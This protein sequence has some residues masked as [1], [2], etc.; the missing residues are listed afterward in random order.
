[1][2]KSSVIIYLFF[3][4]FL[5]FVVL[6][7][8]LA[9]NSNQQGHHQG[10]RIKNVD[11]YSKL[12][13]DQY[14]QRWREGL[15]YDPGHD[16]VEADPVDYIIV[17][18][19]SAGS[20]LANR[21]SAEENKFSVLVI[22]A[23]PPDATLN[24]AIEDPFEM[25][26]L[27]HT[28]VDWGYWT[29]NQ[30][31][32]IDQQGNPR[33]D[34]WP[35]GKTWGGSSSINAMLYIRG[36]SVDYDGWDEYMNGAG[37]SYADCLP[38]FKRAENNEAERLYQS[39]FHGTDGP[40][41]VQD[42]GY[43]YDVSVAAVRGATE[44]LGVPYNPDFNGVS[45]EGANLYQL[46]QRHSRRWSTASAYLKPALAAKHGLF[47]VGMPPEL[48]GKVLGLDV[49]S[50][51][52][53]TQ[54]LTTTN[55]QGQVFAYGVEYYQG[56]LQQYVRR[57]ATKEVILAAGAISDPQILTLSGIGPQAELNRLGIPVVQ[58]LPGVGQNLMDHLLFPISILSPIK[59]STA[60]SFIHISSRSGV[61]IFLRSFPE[62]EKTPDIQISVAPSLWDADL[63]I[64]NGVDAFTFGPA[65]NA[66]LSRGNV[67]VQSSD[68]FQYP[69]IYANYLSDPKGYDLA[70][71][72]QSFKYSI[73]ILENSTSLKPFV[74]KIAS[75]GDN[76][77]W[78]NCE[79][80]SEIET[81]I[82]NKGG[83]SF[84]ASGTC[85]M[86][87]KSD[88]LAVVDKDLK[89]YGVEN[90]R[91][92]SAS[93]MPILPHGNLNAPVIMI[94]EKIA[95]VILGLPPLPPQKVF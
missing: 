11:R 4:S 12:R 49:E 42:V 74:G 15:K 14:T 82:K 39:P 66:P 52:Y 44:A 73:A 43:P 84:H 53:V 80:D 95:D 48:G 94:A 9:F 70:R 81:F 91:V 88:P 41:F 87:P 28:A 57:N 90:L 62:R 6:S 61:G 79:T 24:R 30:S 89:V 59:N 72:V 8:A 36:Q 38:Y 5:F 1:M 34:Y 54:V 25:G 71:M 26:N 16:W 58:N 3:G 10:H 33:P 20:V 68:P 21:L 85:K 92:V 27:W 78:G 93:V 37:W 23:G 35:K 46:T 50:N 75:F 29:V 63:G 18:A 13:M 65:L 45:Q 64:P 51:S 22:E 31:G 83:S 7:S 55:Y 47:P 17:G 40:L 2:T 69:L 86:G 60:Q 56:E 77:P 32:L 76:F 19:G 67:T